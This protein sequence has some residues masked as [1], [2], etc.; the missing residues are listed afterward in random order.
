M[1]FAIIVSMLVDDVEAVL[2]YKAEQAAVFCH[3]LRRLLSSI[4]L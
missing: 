2:F 3:R 1:S 4:V